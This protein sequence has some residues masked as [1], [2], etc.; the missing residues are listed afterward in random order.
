[1]YC[2]IYHCSKREFSA[3][4]ILQIKIVKLKLPVTKI[5]SFLSEG[6]LMSLAFW[7]AFIFLFFLVSVW[8]IA[9]C[10]MWTGRYN[11]ACYFWLGYYTEFYT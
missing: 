6:K 1:M 11:I 2:I 4:D 10:A 7:E 3:S 9:D 5:L 8:I